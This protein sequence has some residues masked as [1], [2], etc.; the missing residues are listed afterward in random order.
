MIYS[1]SGYEKAI[2]EI[3]QYIKDNT[4]ENLF[5]KVLIFA[6]LKNRF[7]FNIELITCM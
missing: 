1:L 6:L 3:M 5:M 7:I 4:E 2:E